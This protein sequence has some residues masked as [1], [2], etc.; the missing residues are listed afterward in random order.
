[1]NPYAIYAS[2]VVVAAPG[3]VLAYGPLVDALGQVVEGTVVYDYT[4]PLNTA[5]P[6]VAGNGDDGVDDAAVEQFE[7]A[8]V[9]FKQGRYEQALALADRALATQPNDATIHEFRALCQFALG[10]YNEAAATL[11]AVLAVGP[12]W[13]WPTL[14]SLY[15]DVTVYTGQIRALEAYRDQHAKE[16]APH[17][18]CA[19][20]YLTQGHKEA[21][22]A[23]L[24]A[25]V[26]LEPKDKLAA[27]LLAGLEGQAKPKI[28]VD[29]LPVEG[30]EGRAEAEGTP[31]ADPLG[32]LPP[33]NEP[34]RAG[35]A[36]GVAL[37]GS[38]LWEAKPDPET[39]I[40]LAFLEGDRF[41]WTV[42]RAGQEPTI[43]EGSAADAKGVLT[44]NS[45]AQGA[46]V[47]RVTWTG[48]DAFRFRLLGAPDDDP[49]LTFRRAGN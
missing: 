19:Y 3:Q 37:L 23:E 5:A 43:I 28:V 16:A 25:V 9:A 21:A 7:Q 34:A 2:P 45:A 42:E 31:A 12:G 11:Y 24:K 14:I 40:R 8:R 13:D 27:Q 49:G 38:G 26:R 17:F 6:E 33:L 47:G 44:L 4:R 41:R 22:I 20:H 35:E 29:A 1:M 32:D 18:V 30:Q 46:L 48:L 10:R 15:P 39:T 36:V